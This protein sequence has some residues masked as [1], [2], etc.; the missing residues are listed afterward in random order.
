M[1]LNAFSAAMHYPWLR[2][3]LL[4]MKL[5]AIIVLV[6]LL[7][8][9]A[10]GYGQ[11]INLDETNLSL[12]KVLHQINKQTGYVFF[13]DSKD[14][15]NKNVTIHL[16]DAS[17][18]EALKECLRNQ[19]L[20]YKIINN[21]V[22]LQQA[23]KSVVS[24]VVT[25][26]VVA[27][28]TITGQVFDDK[29]LPLSGVTIKV[30]GSEAA[31]ISDANGKFSIVVPDGKT[32]LVFSFIGFVKKE[33]RATPG[34]AMLVKLEADVSGLSEVVVVA[35]GTQNKENLTGAVGVIKSSAL[36]DRP[37]SS[38][39]NLL[40]GLSPGVTVTTQGS[41]PGASANIKIRESSTWQGGTDPLFVIDG[42]VRDA[43]TFATINPADIDN[44]SLLKDAASTAIYGIRGGN[45][46]V[47]VT[48][49]HGVANKTFISYNAS[50][51]MNNREITPRRMNAFEAYTFAND[52]Y[53]QK[54]LPATDPS[55]YTPDELDYFKTHS[56]DW[57]KDTWTN[58]WNTSHNLSVS[59]GSAA[60]RYYISAGYL[61]QDGATS[62]SFN[63][64]NLTAKLDGQISERW[65]YNL[66]IQ[67]EWNNGSR[68]F[69]AYDYGDFNLSNMYNRLLMVNPGR[70]SFIN[71]L[72]VANF[73]NTNTANLAKG[74][75]GYT[76]PSGNNITPTFQLKY[77]I[78]GI[79]GLSAKGTFAYNTSNGFTKA[80]RNAP[81][82]YYFQTKGAHNH[83]ITDQL[84]LTRSGG[85]QIL[86]QAQ[87]SGVGAPTELEESYTQSSNYQL[88]LM[89]NYDRSFGLH[90]ISAFAGYE[91]SAYR[92]HYSNI[93]DDNYSN[94]NYQQING[95]STNSTDWYIRGD[96]NQPTGFAS[97]FGR[98]D[99]NYASKYLLGFTMRADGSYIF[100]ANK[101]WGYFPAVSAGW[102]IA[103]EN[104]FADYTKYLDVLKLRVSYGITGTD[105]TAP[106]Q[107]QQT[108][109]FNANSGIYLGSG[110]PPS[111]TLGSTI[112]PN[113]TWEKNH[114]YNLGLDFGMPKRILTGTVDLWYKKT[115][116]ILGT[117]LASVPNTVGASLPA[118]NYG[119][120]SAKGIE[121]SLSH[122]KHINNFFYRVS[123]NWS[124][125]D[126]KYL[127]VDQAAS[128]RG[129]QN[130]I[131]QP[132]NG[133]IWGYVS[134]GIIRTQQD[135]DNILK[136]N[137]A[138]FTIFGSKPQ[139]GMLMYKD[140]RGPLGTDAPDGKID[141][142][143][144]QIISKNGIP[145][146]NYGFNFTVGWKGLNLSAIFTGLGRYDI[147]PTDVYY[148]RP[149]PGNDNLT[150][151]KGAWT[152][153]TAATATM[154]SA[155]MNDWQG[156]SNSEVPS[157]FWLKN[158]AFLRLKSLIVDY[159][160]PASLL[161]KSKIKAVKIYF[162]GENL[163]QW[164]HVGDWDPELGG[165]FRMYPVLR[166]FTCG[167]NVTF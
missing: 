73:D 122:E 119:I 53:A 120:A 66:N 151:W 43:A 9:S 17:I 132:I 102:N 46:V 68:P 65:S 136:A 25:D 156:T 15:L 94:P 138:N 79:T 106:W 64:Y 44:I 148:R 157:T 61:R 164:N 103:K 80:W 71:G 146:V 162:S 131:G 133:V 7:Q 158:G 124:Y 90:N 77:D 32:I 121:L 16:K 21:N 101:R 99:Y 93:W 140:I 2:K 81:Y 152:A 165:D 147:M 128:V 30:K 126:N 76:R 144:Q 39:A 38:P 113:I 109:N 161:A 117:R 52:A 4:V 36:E 123:A 5:T 83:I 97:Y 74:N 12:K 82:I 40:Q 145:R 6:A 3:T 129:Y 85:Y 107:W 29:N 11:K 104:F 35:Y 160:L 125:S 28:V 22:V 50:Y 127:K 59:G 26:P 20:T 45:G 19:S 139:P 98:V 33:V 143:D 69:W 95:G 155:I 111:T 31:T 63:K 62:N 24:N 58:P 56:Y 88:D 51:T 75:G 108:Y 10:K 142:N 114:N 47:L 34:S 112:N 86:D 67:S 92:G 14:V 149:L 118:V 115:T 70:P 141:G 134:D 55:F 37:T 1:K 42:F 137:G 41:Y 89:L 154:P 105:N 150:V 110:L 23:D 78:P 72:P 54:G 166:G 91:Q 116:D 18:D 135:V 153:Q 57:L 8:C 84:D 163:Y 159:S 48:T 96:Q 49:K 100:P 27:P 60:A 167:L 130:L 87:I 13:Y